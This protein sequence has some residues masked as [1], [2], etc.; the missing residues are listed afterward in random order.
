MRKLLLVLFFF[1]ISNISIAQ[2]FDQQEGLYTKINQ[3]MAPAPTAASIGTYGDYSVSSYTGLPDINIP[4]FDIQIKNF[5][6]PIKLNYNASGIKVDDVSSWVGT[7]WSL[8]AGGIVTRS[9]VDVPD[10]ADGAVLAHGTGCLYH[11]WYAPGYNPVPTQNGYAIEMDPKVT[12]QDYIGQILGF[13]IRGKLDAEPDIFYFNFNGKSGK[14]IFNPSNGLNIQPSP[15]NN[16]F[17]GK[18]LLVP[19]QDLKVDVGVNNTDY[20]TDPTYGTIPQEYYGSINQFIITDEKG[21]KYYFAAADTSDVINEGSTESCEGSTTTGSGDYLNTSKY[22]SSWYISKIVTADN[23]SINFTYANE[24]YSYYVPNTTTARIMNYSSINLNDDEGC[25]L[26]TLN[27]NNFQT[28]FDISSTTI[29]GVRLTNIT[30]PNFMVEFDANLPRQDMYGSNALTSV[31]LYNTINGNNILVKQ[32]S[33]SYNYMADLSKPQISYNVILGPQSS[34]GDSRQHLML[35]TI[36]LIDQNGNNVSNYNF[37]YNNSI[38]LPDR[39]S[40]QKDF[41]GYFC[42]NDCSG[43]IPK[44]YVYPDAIPVTSD[45]PSPSFRYSVIPKSNYTGTVYVLPGADR[46]TNPA[47]ILSGTLNNIQFPTGGS[48]NFMFEPNTFVYNGQTIIGGGLRLKQSVSYDGINHM[49]DII[50]NYSYVKTSDSTTS[51]GVLFNLPVFAYSENAYTYWTLNPNNFPSVNDVHTAFSQDDTN[52]YKFN[53]VRSNVP[54]GSLGGF[55]GI[56]VGY[57][58]ITDAQ[59]GNGKIVKRYS[60]PGEFGAFDDYT[61][62]GFCNLAQSGFC[63]GY[64]QAPVPITIDP[65]AYTALPPALYQV[66]SSDLPVAMDPTGLDWNI[67]YTFPFAP[68]PNYDWN[69]GLVLS[70]NY[71]N[72]NNNLVKTVNYQYKL[73][74]PKNSGITYVNC[75]KTGMLMNYATMQFSGIGYWST[76]ANRNLFYPG[77][78]SSGDGR[79]FVIEPYQLLTQVC[80]VPSSKT[81]YT[82]DQ[83]SGNTIQDNVVYNYQYNNTLPSSQTHYESDG[84]T[85]TVYTKYIA[86]IDN[87]Q[88]TAIPTMLG[89]YN[90]ENKHVIDNV[91]ERYTQVTNTSNVT[92]TTA[93]NYLT[94]ELNVPKIA[95][96]FTL[97]P[98]S[99]LQDFTPSI[100]TYNNLVTDSRYEADAIFDTYDLNG[101]VLQGHK[102]NDYTYSFI[103]DYKSIYPIAQVMNAAQSDIAYT[104]FEAEGTGNWTLTGGA[105]NMNI[106]LTG[107]YSYTLYSGNDISE[108]ELTTGNYTVSYWTTGGSLKVN[109]STGTFMTSQGGW[110]LYVH[111]LIGI[112]AVTV[113]GPGTLDELRLYPSNAQMTTYTYTPLV[114]KTSECD[115]SNHITYYEYDAFAR[116]KDIRDQNRNIIKEYNY[117]YAANTTPNWVA[118]TTPETLP[119]GDVVNSDIYQCKPCSINPKYST[120]IRQQQLIDNNPSSPSYDQTQWVDLPA[121]AGPT[122]TCGA[123]DW[124][125]TTPTPA[126]QQVNGNNTGNQLVSTQDLNPCSSTYN[127]VRSETLY[128]I[129]AC[130]APA[131]S[132]QVNAANFYVLL[133]PTDPNYQYS[134]GIP[135]QFTVQFISVAGTYT[136]TISDTQVNQTIGNIPAGN[137]IVTVTPNNQTVAY[138]YTIFGNSSYAIGAS[139]IPNVNVYNCNGCIAVQ[140][141]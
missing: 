77:G 108:G 54:Q 83:S 10:D 135:V 107:N 50:H 5:H 93:G 84:K 86:D 37:Q 78:Y 36:N 22:K 9:V 131:N 42:N 56:N 67:P 81:T 25:A 76:L 91:V 49:N 31:K 115:A 133:P 64:F 132:I 123:A 130:P 124:E 18:A 74:T 111:N 41:W 28:T 1:Y 92:T 72:A 104:S 47:S 57:S 65:Y 51:S 73:F 89:Y 119:S 53:T 112:N 110:N 139:E 140:M 79:G 35:D 34:P 106:G 27:D 39:L 69:R 136:F 58:E 141:D 43:D 14:F 6:L 7:G 45:V 126:C 20:S 137:Y 29:S 121:I 96:A 113:S 15:A 17:C 129:N 75:L 8:D 80:K 2:S 63:D 52:Y 118:N 38:P 44:L 23:D 120:N 40:S 16:I 61:N 128:N 114:G 60:V 109:G 26:N 102:F 66:L 4:L 134:Y 85:T 103:W 90:M 82:Y 19:Y 87:S 70:E 33:L 101:N 117:S 138:Q 30:G 32:Y 94:Y 68:L 24:I 98:S 97:R 11:N 125:Q 99:P 55:D 127:T 46:N 122:Y 3:I 62:N 88:S 48:T 21:N 71:F 116:L 105:V 100:T 13:M 12:S 95:E 59:V